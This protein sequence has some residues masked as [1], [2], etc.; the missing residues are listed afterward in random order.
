MVRV[1]G[2]LASLDSSGTLANALTYITSHDSH[3]V[4]RHGKPSNPRTA[5]QT[6]I[7]S[8]MTWLTTSWNTLT[9]VQQTSW[10]TCRTN[11]T[12]SLY[13]SYLG[14]NQ[15]RWQTGHAPTQIY[16]TSETSPLAGTYGYNC[17]PHGDVSLHRIRNRSPLFSVAYLIFR[18]TQPF[19]TPLMSYLVGVC[20]VTTTEFAWWS[21]RPPNAPIYYYR[22]R[23]L[24]YDG[25]V[26]SL[27]VQKVFIPT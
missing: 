4:K 14:H 7:R 1:T 17:N 18:H 10:V 26:G 27:S 20:P 19:A 9:P 5:K 16:P 15:L 21:D 6:A 8:L 23:S 11:S 12:T 25:A 22:Y 3:A 13:H 2:P 24:N